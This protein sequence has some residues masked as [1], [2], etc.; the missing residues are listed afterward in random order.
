MWDNSV[1]YR[2]FYADHGIREDRLDELSPGDLPI[3]NEK[4]LMEHFDR[5]VTDSRLT[6]S[7]IERC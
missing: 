1:F 4:R 7:V 6:K 2:D 3:I 5:A